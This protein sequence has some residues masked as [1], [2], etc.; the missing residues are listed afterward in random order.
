MVKTKWRIPFDSR[1]QKVSESWPFEC[2]IVRLSD[3]YCIHL[4]DDFL[5]LIFQLWA[6]KIRSKNTNIKKISNRHVLDISIWLYIK[7]TTFCCSKTQ[8]YFLYYEKGL[9]YLVG[10]F[11]WE[12]SYLKGCKYATRQSDSNIYCAVEYL[13]SFWP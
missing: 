3:V 13:M 8:R 11:P 1:T 10:I 12:E 2:Q 6:I 4:F 7:K 9:V 5:T